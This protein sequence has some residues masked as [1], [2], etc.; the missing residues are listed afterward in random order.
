ME[1]IVL[2]SKKT[3]LIA[4]VAG[5]PA[6]LLCAFLFRENLAQLA[7]YFPDCFWYDRLHFLCPSCGNTRSV[8]SLLNGD[9]VTSLRYN[10]TPMLYLLIL[11]AFYVESAAQLLGKKLTVFPRN[12]AFWV[13]LIA[14]YAVYLVVRN[15]I[16]YLSF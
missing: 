14:A 9:V 5:F 16:S 15:F 3:A 4:F 13:V 2:K 6:I 12:T 10:I 7:H 1:G 8:L 11:A